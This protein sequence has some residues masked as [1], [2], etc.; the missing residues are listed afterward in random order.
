MGKDFKIQEAEKLSF[1][2]PK[3]YDTFFRKFIR[4][5]RDLSFIDLILQSTLIVVPMAVWMLSQKHLSMVWLL[6]YYLINGFFLGPFILMLHNT[7]HRALFKREYSY[8][9]LYIPWILSPFFGLTP[10][11]YFAHHVGMHHPENNLEDDLSSTL[12]YRRDSFVDFM[13]YFS[14]FFFLGIFQIPK[15]FLNQRRNKMAMW[16]MVGELSFF[17]FVGL[18][19]V[20]N[21]RGAIFIFVIP[22]V[23]TRFMMMNGNWAQHAFVDGSYPE[24]NYKNS[25]TCINSNYNRRCFNDGYH[26]SH[27]LQPTCHWQDVPLHLKDHLNLYAQKDAILFEKIDYFVIWILLMLKRYDWLARFFVDLREVKRSREE[28]IKFLKGRTQPDL[29]IIKTRPLLADG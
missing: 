27:H 3:F 28:V 9:N 25:I 18:L 21:W 22:F 7:C 11:T 8:L 13:K 16:V 12:R 17:S 1:R 5:P 19:C 20:W 6:V 26:I 4:D 23:I 10:E 15:Y 24:D 29:P 14:R 2:S